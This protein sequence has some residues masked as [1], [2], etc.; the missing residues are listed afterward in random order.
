MVMT[1]P[2]HR[3]LAPWKRLLLLGG[4]LVLTLS[5]ATA[6]SAP[7][8]KLRDVRGQWFRLDKHIG[9]EVVYITFW[10]T[11]CVPCRREMPHLQKMYDELADQG[12]LVVGINTDPAS[13]QSKV[14]PWLSRYKLTFPTVFDP[15]N[16][17]HDKYNP[18]RELPFGVLIDRQGNIHKTFAGYRP[19]EEK[20]LE[21]E[22]L[23]LLEPSSGGE[24]TAEAQNAATATVG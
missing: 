11:W 5:T 24:P 7:D 9:N 4:V 18:T 17:V 19:G 14:K 23:K 6:G 8:F 1:R 22:I 3:N 12:L 2:A 20:L 16:N 10:A 21:E 13:S 15:D